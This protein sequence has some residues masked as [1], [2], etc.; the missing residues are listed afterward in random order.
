M[1]LFRDVK[2]NQRKEIRSSLKKIYGV[3]WVKSKRVCA[4]IGVSYPFFLQNLSIYKTNLLLILLKYSVISKTRINRVIEVNIHRLKK[5][6]CYK[7][8]RHGLCLSVRGQRS[9]TNSWTQK[10]KRDKK[11]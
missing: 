8:I 6:S 2:L 10:N 9:R 11:I 4:K 1:L 5:I 3:G 7:G